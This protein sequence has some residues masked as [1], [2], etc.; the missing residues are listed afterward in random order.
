MLSYPIANRGKNESRQMAR[1]DGTCHW[2]GNFPM[3]PTPGLLELFLRHWQE[4]Q[5][6]GETTE[7]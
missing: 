2:D 7:M 4:V 5:S 1:L 6:P 3:A